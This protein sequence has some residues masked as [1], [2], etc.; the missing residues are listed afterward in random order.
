MNARITYLK[1]CVRHHTPDIDA[2]HVISENDYD[3]V[4]DREE[5]FRK[6]YFL[7]RFASEIPVVIDEKELLLGSMRFAAQRRPSRNKGHIAVDYRML[8]REGIPGVRKMIEKQ[9]T[10]Y[11]PAFREAHL[12]FSHW[13]SRH[14]DAAAAYPALSESEKTCRALLT[15]APASF[16]EALQ[17]IWFVHVFLHAEGSEA[18]VSFG[19][20]D[21][22][23]YPFYEH[24][25]QNGILTREEAKELLMCF[26]LKTCEGDESQ[27]LTLGGPTEN[28]LTFLC[29]EVTFELKVT[30]PSVSVRISPT[31]S[32]TLWN[33]TIDLIRTGIGMPAIFN[34]EVIVRALSRLGISFEDAENYAIIG[35]YEANPDGVTFGTTAA[36]GVIF[37][38]TILQEF[39]ERESSYSSFDACYQD[40]LSYLKTFYDT[41]ALPVFRK[42]W[43]E[44][45]TK[46][47]SPF[48]AVCFDDCLEKG[49]PC[50]LGGCRYTMFGINILGIGTIIDS[51]YAIKKIVFEQGYD[52]ASF[53]DQVKHNFPDPVLAERCRNL[54]GKYGTDSEETNTMANEISGVIAE[55]VENG[56]IAEGV[57]PYAGLFIF[58][59]DVHSAGYRATPDGRRDGDRLSY[60]I[61]ASDLCLGKTVTSLL[62]SATHI[63][64]DRFADGNPLLFRLTERETEGEK[65]RELLKALIRSYF[66]K[67]GFQLQ[68]NVCR[69]D[70]LRDAQRDPDS[71]RDLVVRISGYSE[72]FTRL[73]VHVQN[74]LIERI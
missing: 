15:R 40:F 46:M 21:D 34:D 33:Q 47:V 28:E 31:T 66:E 59:M 1:E 53:I 60:G 24:D 11:T 8:L 37:L 49:T 68:I 61:A 74:A 52:Y 69:A 45:Q 14:A 9:S 48:Q 62:N 5:V 67:G 13:I 12:A 36:G 30:Q 35:C 43:E 42:N 41:V 72:Y 44:I 25:L 39:L 57:I 65:G 51:M 55:L 16:R 63:Q 64:N 26:W 38:N 17:L 56:T 22:Y 32:D 10:A 4:T 71:Y 3:R 50:E 58:L 54:P 73:P 7:T 19:R 20:F 29:L 18:A 70:M 23:L 6:A 2:Y 27:N